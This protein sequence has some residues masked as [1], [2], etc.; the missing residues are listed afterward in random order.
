MSTGKTMGQIVLFYFDQA[1]RN[2][3]FQSGPDPGSLSSKANVQGIQDQKRNPAAGFYAV[4]SKAKY[5][6]YL[7]T[8]RQEHKRS[9]CYS[10]P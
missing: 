4:T 8:V 6:L 10:I 9:I 5:D 3:G 2:I 1:P 7:N